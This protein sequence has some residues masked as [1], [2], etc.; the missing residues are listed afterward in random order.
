VKVKWNPEFKCEPKTTT[1]C[2]QP[3]SQYSCKAKKDVPFD[4]CQ[5]FDRCDDTSI[6]ATVARNS[7]YAVKVFDTAAGRQAFNTPAAATTYDGAMLTTANLRPTPNGVD[8]YTPTAAAATVSDYGW[9]VNYGGPA[10][11]PLCSAAPTNSLCI[12]VDPTTSTTFPYAPANERTATQA[13]VVGG[14]AFW[15]TYTPADTVSTCGNA[16]NGLHT[17][18]H[19]NLYTGNVCTG[20][21][22]G[23]LTSRG[24]TS[25]DSLPP[26]PPQLTV[27]LPPDGA[28]LPPLISITTVPRGAG[29]SAPSTQVSNRSSLKSEAYDLDV[30]NGLH[31]CRHVDSTMPKGTPA[32]VSTDLP[33][34]SLHGAAAAY[35]RD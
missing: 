2:G 21:D 30:P 18:Y 26:A 23:L 25:L 35:C 28:N 4:I 34:S 22:P 19:L 10:T 11:R 32:G 9:F 31:A 3:F 16:A 20:L 29:S 14:C 33:A 12:P 7:F 8:P 5:T 17:T 6:E 15:N 13:A 24:T 27:F 1:V